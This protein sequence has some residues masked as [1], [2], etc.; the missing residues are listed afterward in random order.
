MY[1]L[2]QKG[3]FKLKAPFLLFLINHI[4]E[5]AIGFHLDCAEFTWRPMA[6]ATRDGGKYY[7][8]G[9]IYISLLK[10]YMAANTADAMTSV[11]RFKPFANRFLFPL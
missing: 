9:V 1:L 4:V 11:W 10:F 2:T 8:Y 5:E 7:S 3:T 6:A